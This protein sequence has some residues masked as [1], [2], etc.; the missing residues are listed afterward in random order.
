MSG[1]MQ[2]EGGANRVQQ[3]KQQ[4]AAN[5]QFP[6]PLVSRLDHLD[7]LMKYLEGKQNSQKGLGGG[8]GGG[9]GEAAKQQT[10]ALLEVAMREA[11]FKGSLLDRVASLEHRL[12][13]LCL[14]M[15]STNTSTSSSQTSGGGCTSAS[16]TTTTTTATG[17][18]SQTPSSSFPTFSLSNPRHPLLHHHLAR[19]HLQQASIHVE[20]EREEE[21]E[22]KGKDSKKGSSSKTRKEEKKNCRTNGNTHSSNKKQ[23]KWPQIR[24]LKLLGC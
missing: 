8:G 15:E 2:V 14:E 5:H 9:G 4:A 1:I 19:S 24:P 16:S 3:H 18:R 21:G 11:Y 13:Q 17:S 6:V 12:F 22:T 20:E 10:A 7:S 23:I